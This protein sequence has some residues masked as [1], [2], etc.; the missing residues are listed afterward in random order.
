MRVRPFTDSLNAFI[1]HPAALLSQGHGEAGPGCRGLANHG[2]GRSDETTP[3]AAGISTRAQRN[4]HIERE[5]TDPFA[6]LP[7][8][9]LTIA[10]PGM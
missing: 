4:G 10:R 8:F 2:R 3:G 7:W 1:L 6:L 9:A 5:R